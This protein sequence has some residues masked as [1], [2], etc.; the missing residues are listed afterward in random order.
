MRFSKRTVEWKTDLKMRQLGGLPSQP[1]KSQKGSRTEQKNR[2]G[3]E[4][5]RNEKEVLGKKG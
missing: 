3:V 5:V 4:E 2:R 1:M